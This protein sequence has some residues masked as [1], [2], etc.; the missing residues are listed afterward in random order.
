MVALLDSGMLLGTWRIQRPINIHGVLQRYEAVHLHTGHEARVHCA[1]RDNDLHRQ[2]PEHRRSTLLSL[3]E[4]A[5]PRTLPILDCGEWET[6]EW[7]CTQ[8]PPQGAMPLSE[9]L[10][11]HGPLSERLSA[12]LLRDLLGG[13]GEHP[14][15]WLRPS[16][17]WVNRE[18]ALVAIS[19][20]GLA[21]LFSDVPAP[22]DVCAAPEQRA[23][24]QGTAADVYA[25]G[26]ILFEAL[27]GME[28]FHDDPFYIARAAIERLPSVARQRRDL[29]HADVFDRLIG[30]LS[31][32]RPERRPT[33]ANALDEA[34]SLAER[35][36]APKAVPC[37]LAVVLPEGSDEAENP[38]DLMV[39]QSSRRPVDRGRAGGDEHGAATRDEA[40]MN[41]AEYPLGADEADEKPDVQD[42]I[43]ALKLALADMGVSAEMADGAPVRAEEHPKRGRARRRAKRPRENRP[44]VSARG[45]GFQGWRRAAAA[46]CVC[47]LFLAAAHSSSESMEPP[48]TPKEEEAMSTTQASLP[49]LQSQENAWVSL[50]IGAEEEAGPP[51]GSED[52]SSR[53]AEKQVQLHDAKRYV[54]NELF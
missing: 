15:L 45:T 16:V 17:L 7:A 40:W 23:R 14:H 32:K 30:R 37:A 34:R 49:E 5:P 38:L 3:R 52:R 35:L 8:A 24:M 50:G 6:L 9:C 41:T 39:P 51:G 33:P 43:A 47:G 31:D 54:G 11:E 48:G 4:K 26:M 20:Y 27:T 28:P 44:A 22:F 25:C 29:K 1:R 19:E 21:H 13:L 53:M 46:V 36:N 2:T 42:A 12:A 10:I 18:R